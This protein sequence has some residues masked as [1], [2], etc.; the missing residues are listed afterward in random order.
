MN[1]VASTVEGR[2]C[3]RNYT[4]NA[5]EKARPVPK[6]ITW[7]FVM[8]DACHQILATEAPEWN[9][10]IHRG[11]LITQKVPDMTFIDPNGNA[12]QHVEFLNDTNISVLKEHYNRGVSYANQSKEVVVVNF[13][14]L[15]PDWD[16]LYPSQDILKKLLPGKTMCV[17]Q[18][19]Y[20]MKEIL[21]ISEKVFHG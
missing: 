20:S 3:K 14:R 17:Q 18:V 6:E 15:H 4:K 9:L 13:T 5:D 11:C 8:W 1:Y 2:S 10:V 21:K 7:H 16:Y 12:Y 19:Y